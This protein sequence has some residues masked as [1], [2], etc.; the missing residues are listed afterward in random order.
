MG[1][2]R[3]KSQ[4]T[5]EGSA[6]YT[7][8]LQAG[9]GLTVRVRYPEIP[10]I[11]DFAAW[12]D[13]ATCNSSATRVREVV[14]QWF[15]LKIQRAVPKATPSISSGAAIRVTIRVAQIEADTTGDT[16]AD[17]TAVPTE[18]TTTVTVVAA[19]MTATTV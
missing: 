7:D 9:I 17:P 18:D 19:K 1:R 15:V 16:T 14:P 10:S 11:F 5:W 2:Q 6:R 4:A 3:L 12:T 13:G 8:N